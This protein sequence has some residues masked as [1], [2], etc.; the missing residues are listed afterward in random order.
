MLPTALTVFTC[1]VLHLGDRAYEDQKLLP[2]EP[3]KGLRPAL[4]L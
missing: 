2:H 3:G 1:A 4:L